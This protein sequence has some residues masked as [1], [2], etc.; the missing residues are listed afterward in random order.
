M[1][2][3]ETLIFILSF[4][5]FCFLIRLSFS[6]ATREHLTLSTAE[7][8]VQLFLILTCKGRALNLFRF[9]TMAKRICCSFSFRGESH[10]NG[11]HSSLSSGRQS[12][13][14]VVLGF[15]GLSGGGDSGGQKN[16]FIARS[17]F[18]SNSSLSLSLSLA[19]FLF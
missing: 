13:E 8:G 16:H 12:L 10:I 9:R 6:D 14:G 18:Q 2:R 17:Y 11:V 15:S 7:N 1:K 4:F 3:F 5:F 19:L